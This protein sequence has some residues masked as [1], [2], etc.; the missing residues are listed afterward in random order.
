MVATDGP[1]AA[2]R[3]VVKK[4]IRYV[5]S[6]GQKLASSLHYAPLPQALIDQDQKLVEQMTANGKPLP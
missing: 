1:D 6:D 5:V 3:A 4:F 2:K